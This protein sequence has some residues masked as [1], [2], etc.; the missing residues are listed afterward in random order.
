VALMMPNLLQYPVALF[1]VL[2][3]GLVVVNV[4]PQY[5]VPE[6][7]HQLKDSGAVAIVCWRTSPTRCRKPCSRTPR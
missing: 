6:L 2:R 7:Q 1:G 5:T 4:N 3:A